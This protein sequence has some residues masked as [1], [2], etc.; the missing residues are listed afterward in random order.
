MFAYITIAI[1]CQKTLNIRSFDTDK[2]RLNLIFGLSSL[3]DKQLLLFGYLNS[4]KKQIKKK[5]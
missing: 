1:I 2:T 5:D 4:S 3:S